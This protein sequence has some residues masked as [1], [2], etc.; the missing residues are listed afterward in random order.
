MEKRENMKNVLKK[1]FSYKLLFVYLTYA[2]LLTTAMFT[3][4]FLGISLFGF[5][6]GELVIGFALILTL[7]FFFYPKPDLYFDF[8]SRRFFIVHKLIVLYVLLR[9][10][11]N[12]ENIN[13]YQFKSSS[14]IWTISI[15]YFGIYV[16]NLYKQNNLVIIGLALTPIFVYIFQ[17]GNYPNFLISIFQNYSDKFQFMKAADMVIVTIVSSL[18][19]KQSQSNKIVSV[20]YANFLCFLFLPL[21]AINSRGAVLGLIL[22]W[23]IENANNLSLY[24]KQK[25]VI[26]I[27]LLI[28][29]VT[30]SFSSLRVSNIGSDVIINSDEP[31]LSGLPEVVSDI[32]NEKKTQEVFLSFYFSNG[33]INSTDPTTNWRLDIWQDVI[34]DLSK[35]GR[36]L[37]GYGYGEIIP[38]MKDPSAP[39]RLG[40]DGLNENVH[41]YFVTTLARGG[42][43][44]LLLFLFLHFEIFKNLKNTKL[45]K[46]T[47][48]LIVPCLFMSSLD[49][50]MDG[51]QFPLLYYFFVGYFSQEKY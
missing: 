3:R 12:F 40:R 23:V 24:K 36:I 22:F 29:T 5:R 38:V 31:L 30:F 42:L 50:T 4:S 51:V 34:E 44:N 37:Y 11:L 41:N 49:I 7:Y 13:L 28:S 18:Y 19:L 39:G 10:I 17:T 14:F 46:S 8:G 20:I 2:F 45:G 48:S 33:R 21:V 27:L 16:S 9:L 25:S 1:Y 26:I 35:K 15:I 6:I 47:Y 43:I 32:A